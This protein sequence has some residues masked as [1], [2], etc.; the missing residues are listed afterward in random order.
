MRGN[1]LPANDAFRPHLTLSY[2]RDTILPRAIT[3]ICLSFKDFCLIHNERHRG[4]LGTYH[5]L[6]RWPLQAS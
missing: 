1:G 4:Q 6:G 5:V 2:G 3:S